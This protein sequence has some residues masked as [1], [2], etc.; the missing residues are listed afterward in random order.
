MWVLEKAEFACREPAVGAAAVFMPI[1]I[2]ISII[3]AWAGAVVALLPNPIPNPEEGGYGDTPAWAANP[4]PDPPGAGPP[5]GL[6][7]AR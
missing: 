2:P 6:R 3:G 7:D 4:E 5:N 1:P